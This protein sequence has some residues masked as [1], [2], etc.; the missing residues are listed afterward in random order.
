MSSAS[1]ASRQ[2]PLLK[3]KLLELELER[4]EKAKTIE[5]LKQIR[6]RE[7]QEAQSQLSKAKEE[8]QKSAEELKQQMTQQLEK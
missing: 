1:Q 2:D 3:E 6:E 5:L 4:E 8:G 7:L